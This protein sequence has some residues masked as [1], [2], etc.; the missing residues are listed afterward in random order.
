MKRW[1]TGFFMAWGM[2]LSLPCPYRKWDED[3]RPVMI[4]FLPVIGGIIGGIWAAAAWLL[5]QFPCPQAIRALI[6]TALPWLLTG[7]LHLD[8]YMD[9]CDAVLSRRDLETRK[10]ILKDSH[11]GAFSVICLGLLML[12]QWSLFFSA[13][14]V[15]LLGL[16]LIPVAS[17]ACASLAVTS[18]RPMGTSQYAGLPHRGLQPGQAFVLLALLACIALPAVCGKRAALGPLA[19]A[20]VY[21]L[22]AWHGIRQLGGIS[23]DISGFAL[24]LGELAGVASLVLMGGS[25]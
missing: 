5:R 19:A 25:V 21:G 18:L 23:G 13:Q 14:R 17:R 8:G 24:T 10:K 22:S 3:A 12:A 11:C 9:V 16:F 2:F 7:F 15:S 20:L 6:L 1:I 4:S